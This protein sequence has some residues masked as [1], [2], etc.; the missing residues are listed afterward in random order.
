M[1]L[2]TSRASCDAKH[3]ERATQE[4]DDENQADP[5]KDI[6]KYNDK[7]NDIENDTSFYYYLLK[8]DD[9]T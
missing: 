8:S 4:S 3:G 2:I 7:D 9:E 5:P 1:T 6:D